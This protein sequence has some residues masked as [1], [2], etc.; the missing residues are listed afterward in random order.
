MARS[1]GIWPSEGLHGALVENDMMIREI[2]Q[3]EFRPFFQ[4]MGEIECGTHFDPSKPE[5][6]EWLKEIISRRYGSGARFYALHENDEPV[7]VAGIVTEKVLCTKWSRAELT[8]IG[9]FAQHRR[10]GYGTKLL[11]FV[12]DQARDAGCWGLHLLTYAADP[13]AISFYL[14]NGYAVVGAVADTCGPDDEGDVWLR[15]VLAER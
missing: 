13:D 15:K 8:D 1:T 10:K 5:H 3:S 14:R 6:V 2:P 12:E 11:R 7:A 9:V 4:L